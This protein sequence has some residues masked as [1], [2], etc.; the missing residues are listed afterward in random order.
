MG[1]RIESKNGK[2]VIVADDSST[3]KNITINGERVDPDSNDWNLRET[4]NWAE[5][6]KRVAVYGAMLLFC[7]AFWALVIA[8]CSKL[9][10]ASPLDCEQIRDNDQRHYCRAVSIPR[11]SEC[12]FIKSHDLRQECRAKVSK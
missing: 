6:A 9:A 2:V 12:E 5:V 10:H 1:V 4:P 3:V 11:K 7:L 8:G